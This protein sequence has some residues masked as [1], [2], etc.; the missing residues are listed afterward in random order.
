MIG[1]PAFPAAFVPAPSAGPREGFALDARALFGIAA[2]LATVAAVTTLF[3][4]SPILLESRGIAYYSS[5]GGVFSKVHPATPLAL[6]ALGLRCLGSA[7]PVN[8]AWRLL[9]GDR[10][11]LLLLAA[12]AIAAVFAVF[13]DKTPVAPLIDTFVLPAVVFLLLRGLDPTVSRW[14]ATIVTIVLLA[15]AVLAMVEQV[16]HWHLIQLSIPY[17]ATGDPT[18]AN[19]VFSWQA[20]LAE[21]W[22]AWGLLG[23]PLVN[24]LIVGSFVLCLVC[25][26]SDWIP[27]AW[28]VPLI[29]FE[30][31]SLFSFGARTGLVLTALLGAWL[32]AVR[33]SAAIGRGY[34]L[35][36]RTLG[37]TVLVLAM[38]ALAVLVVVQ[39]GFMDKTVDRF[40]NDDGSA[41]T[42]LTMF[43]LFA[44]MSLA[45]MMLHPDKDLVATLQRLYGLEFGI[46]SSWIG[47]ILIYGIVVAAIVIGGLLAFLRSLVRASGRG[48]SLVIGF[49]IVLVS[50]AAVLSGKTTTLAMEVALVLLFL[51]QAVS[52]P[53]ER[54]VP[55]V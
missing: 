47:L 52:T 46:E 33:T 51:R 6:A 29:V 36:P 53:S 34:R 11:V 23:H 37:G 30:S 17:D 41:M 3:A 8:R 45:D 48:A 44:P 2:L 21:D 22:R 10:G 54:R 42:R 43:S 25:P 1:H 38:A 28:R 20:E 26:G 31:V 35:R 40:D 55:K 49:Y 18:S 50:V 4:I 13:V 5:G 27:L 19:G 39:T 16:Q 7:R 15:N 14:L 32:I 9:T 24:G 12:T